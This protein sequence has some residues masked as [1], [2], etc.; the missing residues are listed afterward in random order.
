MRIVKNN[1]V[2]DTDTATL[3]C[4]IDGVK[5]HRSLADNLFMSKDGLITSTH[6]NECL[7][8]LG[9]NDYEQFKAL[10]AELSIPYYE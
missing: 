7:D 2:Y 10:C 5:L 9:N 3:V 1:N 6:Q 8:F 4:E